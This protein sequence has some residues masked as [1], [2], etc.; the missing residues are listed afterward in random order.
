MLTRLGVLVALAFLIGVQP[1]LVQE[2]GARP[3][4]PDRTE[5]SDRQPRQP[6]NDA[7]NPDGVLRLLPVNAVSEKQITLNGKPFAYTSTAGTLSLYNQDGERTAAIY[8]TAYVAKGLG[9]ARRPI[10]FAFNG[11]PGAASAFLHLGLVGPRIMD[12]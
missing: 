5:R 7:A 3:E 9:G 8:Y 6:A 12:F 4:R 11:G 10:T 2:R 1:A